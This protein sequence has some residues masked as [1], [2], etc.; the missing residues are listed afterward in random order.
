[1]P[2]A[3][4]PLPAGWRQLPH[5]VWVGLMLL[6]LLV[7]LHW[8]S[9]PGAVPGAVNVDRIEVSVLDRDDIPPK[10][11]GLPH[12]LDD[13]SPV[14]RH[15]VAYRLDWP[16]EL[17][18]VSREGQRLALLL[19]RVDARFRVLLNDQE[20]Y[21]VGWYASADRTILSGLFP[22]H[23][24]LPAGLL[25]DRPQDNVLVIEVQGVPLERSGLSPFQI[26]EHDPLF[27]RYRVL[28]VWQ[29]MGGW[30]MAIASVF[31]GLI[32]LFLWSSLKERLFLLMA[33]A[34][35]AHVVRLLLLLMLE[36][37]LSPEWHFFVYRLAFNL[38][39]A[40]FCLFIEELFGLQMR[41]VRWLAYFLLVSGPLWLLAAL[42]TESYTYA[43]IW[44]GGLALLAGVSLAMLFVR[45]EW[46]RRINQDQ[47]LV[48]VVAL[49]TLITGVRDFLVLQLHFPGDADI[50]WMSIGSLALM[51][52]LGWV[53]VQRAT[54]STR[55]VH[56]LNQSLAEIVARRESELRQA[57]EQ[58]RVSE[59]QRAVEGERRRL[60]RDMHDGLGSQLV[61]TLNMVRSQRGALDPQSV[62]AMIH[63]ALEELRMTLDSL[64]PMEG[65]LPTILGTFRQ[66][67]APALDS[68]GIALV[69]D[70]QE[71]PALGGLDSR[72]IMHLFRCMQEIFANVVKHSRA[73]E[74]TVRTASDG[75]AV[76][77]YV[78]DNG[79][80]MS[81]DV[82]GGG[83]GRGLGNLRVR[84]AKLGAR[85]H[86]YN[87]KP[88]TGVEFRFPMQHPAP[89]EWADTGAGAD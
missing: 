41:V 67:I 1:M 26:G 49:F 34:S 84:A 45:V 55:E 80:G 11:V 58:L 57:F 7:A 82:A 31:M 50:R 87:A 36:S 79:V 60:M 69:W 39:V 38:Y 88:G 78:E 5:Y 18:Y 13:E 70:V 2:S 35:L 56:R 71:V 8:V 21:S 10:P 44:A 73:T 52:T 59:Q 42:Y 54:A 86:F 77:L 47:T 37:P 22:Y 30:M 75:Q 68:A 72:G 9:R 25:A 65:D 17:D 74:V 85:I 76:Y 64:E 48:M 19:P 46:G 32:S 62:E 29:V 66:R 53:L 23:I 14:W 33:A 27:D 63:H 20:V 6:G 24:P 3:P 51:F 43:R 15:R 61:Q 28:E 12:V 89:T 16:G 4:L 83:G 81:R 40:F